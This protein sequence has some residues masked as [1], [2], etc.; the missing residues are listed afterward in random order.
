MCDDTQNLNE[1]ESE[2][3][4]VT[5]CIQVLEELSDGAY[6]TRGVDRPA[7]DLISQIE[8]NSASHVEKN[9]DQDLFIP[10]HMW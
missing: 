4:S 8:P 9:I 1:T 3:F 5:L 10:A 7:E 6:S 2:T